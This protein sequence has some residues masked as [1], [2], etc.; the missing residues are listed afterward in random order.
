MKH[1]KV[2]LAASAVVVSTAACAAPVT[3]AEFD[4]DVAFCRRTI[5]QACAIVQELAPQATPDAVKQKDALALVATA[6]DQWAKL[7]ARHAANPP[8]EYRSDKAFAVRFADIGH[9]LEDMES[10][11]ADGQARR[12]MLA[13]GFGCGLFVTLHEDNGLVY[14][15]DR[16]FALRK[17]AKTAASVFK[18]R[19][20]DE[21]RALVPTLLR[22]RDEVWMAPLPWP[23]GD[24]RNDAYTAGLRELSAALDR[25]AA[26]TAD[27]ETA[28]AGAILERIVPL[29]NKPYGL[30]L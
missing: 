12:S 23:A 15:L 9:A 13:C 29:I 22:Q 18:A 3:L 4:A 20:L 8:D 25:L 16:L 1:I 5:R 17:T 21:L 19:G 2:L 7:A 30:A 26:A 11:L 24:A 6:R 14:G 10:A 27:D 28:E